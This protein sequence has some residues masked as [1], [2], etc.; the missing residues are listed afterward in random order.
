MTKV[1]R[2]LLDNNK[3]ELVT[4]QTEIKFIHSFYQL[5]KLRYDKGVELTCQVQP[6]FDNYLLPPLTLQLLLE[7][8]VKH[9]ITSKNQ[10][11]HIIIMTTENRRLVIKN[12]LQRKKDKPVSHRIGLENI[13]L[14]YQLLQQEEIIVKEEEGYFIVSIPLIHPT[15]NKPV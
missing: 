4:L 2:Y 7:N 5:L 15:A 1:Y 8:A 10:P 13:A 11:L 3:N 9:N 6:E 14:K 12:N